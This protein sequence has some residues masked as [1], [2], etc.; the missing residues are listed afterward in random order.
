MH[1]F[2]RQV[3]VLSKQVDMLMQEKASLVSR[4]SLLERVVKLK[5]EQ[6]NH[7]QQSNSHLVSC[8]PTL[9]LAAFPWSLGGL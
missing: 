4:N 9:S 3:E 8:K 5:D 1:E 7:Q 6:Q 2:E